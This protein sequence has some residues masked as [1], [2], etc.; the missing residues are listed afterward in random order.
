M[1]IPDLFGGGTAIAYYM[2]RTAPI[3]ISNDVFC[4]HVSRPKLL[5]GPS[6]VTRGNA[7][8][9]L[10]WTRL[11]FSPAKNA[12][13]KFPPKSYRQTFPRTVSDVQ[14]KDFLKYM[15]CSSA[16]L[17]GCN[18]SECLPLHRPTTDNR[19]TDLQ[20]R[21]SSIVHHRYHRSAMTMTTTQRHMPP[22]SY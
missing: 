1:I 10:F 16:T 17:P 11:D 3:I 6:V 12:Y 19:R 9:G 18:R 5:A 2:H 13:S 20:P 22:S 14:T 15:Y 7:G 4:C 8:R 21:P